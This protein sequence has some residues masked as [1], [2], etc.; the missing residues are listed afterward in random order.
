MTVKQ[1]LSLS[2]CLPGVLWRTHRLKLSTRFLGEHTGITDLIFSRV[3]EIL[4]F[5][6][7]ESYLQLKGFEVFSETLC[8]HSL[9]R[10]D[11]SGLL[12]FADQFIELVEKW[13]T[14]TGIM[15]NLAVQRFLSVKR[16]WWST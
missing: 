3:D 12:E 4:A 15:L 11:S 8:F 7:K 5:F 14:K 13:E 2:V 1:K 9:G 16:K 6:F 10:L